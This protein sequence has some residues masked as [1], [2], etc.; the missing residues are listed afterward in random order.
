MPNTQDNVSKESPGQDSFNPRDPAY[1]GTDPTAPRPLPDVLDPASSPTS[2]PT[3]KVQMDLNDEDLFEENNGEMIPESGNTT[4]DAEALSV[5]AIIGIAIAVAAVLA[6]FFYYEQRRHRNLARQVAMLSGPGSSAAGGKDNSTVD[7]EQ[8]ADGF[9]SLPPPASTSSSRKKKSSKRSS[10]SR[11]G[12]KPAASTPLD[13]IKVAIDNTDWDNVYRLASKLA[14]TEDVCTLPDFDETI[15]R[16]HLNEED[17]ERTKT[18]DELI[19]KGDWTGLAVTAALYAGE[20]GSASPKSSKRKSRIVPPN[21]AFDLSLAMVPSTGSLHTKMNR[22]LNEGDWKKVQALSAKAEKKAARAQAM[23]DVPIRLN[24]D[25]DL[26]KG[27]VPAD[28]DGLVTNLGAALKAGDWSQVS[29]YANKIKDEKGA[30]GNS[31]FGSRE[32]DSKAMVVAGQS[33]SSPSSPG[34]PKVSLTTSFE[35]TDSDMSRKMTIEK[36]IK[37]NKWKGVSIMANLYEME[38]K[39]TKSVVKSKQHSPRGSRTSALQHN[40]RV[41]EDSNLVDFRR[42]SDDKPEV[43]YL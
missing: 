17:Q 9:K 6:L 39:Q 21:D 12:I 34:R 27:E 41:V 42:G 7:E 28:M 24:K 22:A 15:Q 11:L 1:P 38:S 33:S 20:S 16:D 35:S 30:S 36:L 13:E 3:N 43:P 8:S 23:S 25:V 32:I 19:S 18:L 29:F 10:S 14:E 5:G 31:S 40:D 26:E 37:A 4:S 2:A